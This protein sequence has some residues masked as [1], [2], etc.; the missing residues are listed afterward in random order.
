MVV[1]RENYAR[2]FF[3]E[4]NESGYVAQQQADLLLERCKRERRLK[5]CEI[6]AIVGASPQL[7]SAWAQGKQ[8]MKT[9]YFNRLKAHLDG[10]STRDEP[11]NQPRDRRTLSSSEMEKAWR[12]L[13]A[14]LAMGYRVTLEGPT[15]TMGR[16]P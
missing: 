16:R 12:H 9:K 5:Q 7:C 3:L 2:G 14:L 4:S 1:Q 10:V 6:A 13:N 15:S 8:Q 11:V